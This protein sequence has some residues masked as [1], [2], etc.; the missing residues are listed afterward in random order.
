MNILFQI[1]VFSFLLL[2]GFAPAHAK[3][4]SN[5]E[6]K[7]LNTLFFMWVTLSA[8]AVTPICLRMIS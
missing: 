1:F 4:L 7:L 6:K 8:I 2:V 5:Y 3:T